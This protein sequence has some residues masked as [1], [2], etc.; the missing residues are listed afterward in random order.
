MES[1]LEI[2][3]ALE[4][5]FGMLYLYSFFAAVGLGFCDS[6]WNQRRNIRNFARAG[7]AGMIWSLVLAL[8]GPY[9]IFSLLHGLFDQ[10]RN[11]SSAVVTF[12]AAALVIPLI[13]TACY[14]SRD[15]I[16]Y[17]TVMLGCIVFVALHALRRGKNQA[18]R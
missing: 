1:T 13:F 4:K 17:F 8:L 16:L 18:G 2:L 11:R 6:L 14:P 10:H 3:G 9:A 15:T 5:H 7:A 12:L